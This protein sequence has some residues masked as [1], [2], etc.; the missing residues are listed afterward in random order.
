MPGSPDC[1]QTRRWN[2]A[3]DDGG[4][5][6]SAS[7]LYLTRAGRHACY[8]RVV[9]SLNGP[10]PVGFAARY[11]R[12]VRAD[13]SGHP[14]PVAGRAFLEVVVRAPITDDA[15]HQP[16]RQLPKVGDALV[17]SATIA[18]FRSLR[19]VTFAGSFE[20][21]TTIAVGVRT[22]RPFRVWTIGQEG[23]RRVVLDVA[24]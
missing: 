22:Q 7:A 11:V 6:M 10:A 20:G 3:P 15:G 23:Y 14:V 21:Q 16:G 18:G 13:G 19:A 12:L 4:L 2:T 8:D 5:E 24:H 9:F 17:P 1:T